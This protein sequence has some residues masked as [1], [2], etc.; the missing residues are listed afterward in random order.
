MLT[1][2]TAKGPN[3]ILIHLLFYNI[4]LQ[5]LTPLLTLTLYT[6]KRKT[7]NACKSLQSVFLLATMIYGGGAIGINC[8][9]TGL[10]PINKN[11][12]GGA[13]DV[14]QCDQGGG[15]ERERVQPNQPLHKEKHEQIS[16]LKPCL[17]YSAC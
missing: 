6:S 3:Q 15:R 7:Q 16:V 10:T 14:Q 2:L 4:K 17:H 8:S 1:T 13:V 5:L 11:Q 12:G 9:T